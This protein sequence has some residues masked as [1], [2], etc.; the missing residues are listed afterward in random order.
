MRDNTAVESNDST[1]KSIIN[2]VRA[3]AASLLAFPF[4]LLMF[5]ISLISRLIFALSYI[6]IIIPA[7]I[8]HVIGPKALHDER[9]RYHNIATH[10]NQRLCNMT[11]WPNK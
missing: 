7:T 2:H 1:L 9:S 6:L 11:N 4:V 10:I 3:W 5:V 8:Y